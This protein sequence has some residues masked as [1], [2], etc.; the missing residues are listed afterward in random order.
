VKTA[1]YEYGLL[2]VVGGDEVAPA[3]R[4]LGVLLVAAGIGL[5]DS[6]AN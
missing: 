5:A 1:V 6:L 2:E 4:A 3:P